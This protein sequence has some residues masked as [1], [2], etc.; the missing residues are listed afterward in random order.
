MNAKAIMRKFALLAIASSALLGLA[1]CVSP[2]SA[3]VVGN[4][5]KK[6]GDYMSGKLRFSPTA[7]IV[8]TNPTSSASAG[9]LI[10]AVPGQNQNNGRLVSFRDNGVEYANFNYSSDTVHHLD[11]PGGYITCGFFT[12]GNFSVNGAGITVSQILNVA[13]RFNVT[14]FTDSSG[15]PG[16]SSSNVMSGRAAFAAAGTA[17]V[18]TTNKAQATSNLFVQLEDLDTTATRVKAVCAAGSCTVTANAAATAT[19]KFYWMLVN[20]Q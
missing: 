20:H 4:F 15:T 6:S 1:I 8:D 2:A 17:V 7:G 9:L 11:V 14:S 18:L 10:D 16:N 13:D 19:T 12:A 3:D 5:V